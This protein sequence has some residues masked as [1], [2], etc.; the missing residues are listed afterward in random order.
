MPKFYR[1]TDGEWV[2]P[3]RRKYKLACCD[4]GLVHTLDFR[5]IANKGGKSIEFRAFRNAR[6]TALARRS[7]SHNPTTRRRT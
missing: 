4:C 7:P 3:R 6:S 5:L 1:V 2:R